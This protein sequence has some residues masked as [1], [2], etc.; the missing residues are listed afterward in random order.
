MTVY[1][2]GPDNEDLVQRLRDPDPLLRAR[3]ATGLAARRD[4]LALPHLLVAARSD[5][6]GGVREAARVATRALLPSQEVADRVV[7][8]QPR[9]AP[10]SVQKARAEASAGTVDTFRAYVSAK[11][12][13]EGVGSV[14]DE[15]HAAVI[16]YLEVWGR[17]SVADLDEA[18]LAAALAI[19][20]IAVHINALSLHGHGAI[21]FLSYKAARERVATY[22]AARDRCF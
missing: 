21:K 11:H 8:A 14:I 13:G 6:D 5:A 17:D 19:R 10:E 12:A 1:V 16:G 15:M 2:I 9:T 20:A 18:G 3:A 7:T 22:D 4:Y